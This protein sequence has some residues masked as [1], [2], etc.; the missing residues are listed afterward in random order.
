MDGYTVCSFEKN[1]IK[2]YLVLDVV[3]DV[4]KSQALLQAFTEDGSC[5]PFPLFLK[6]NPSEQDL[7]N[8]AFIDGVNYVKQ[9]EGWREEG[10]NEDLGALLANP[11]FLGFIESNCRSGILAANINK[12]LN[13]NA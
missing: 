10:R 3:V 4:E 8:A 1:G 6:E 2:N 11:L 5:M 13:S 9:I 7:L 12:L